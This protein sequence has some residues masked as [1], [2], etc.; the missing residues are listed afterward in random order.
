MRSLATLQALVRALAGYEERP[1][2]VALQKGD[3]TTWSYVALAD[4]AQGLATGLVE[5]GLQRGSHV[6]LFAPN[7]P[8]W[9]LACLALLAAA[10]VPVPVD[11]QSS[12]ADLRHVL[13]DSDARW[14]FTTTTLARRVEA[15]GG[16]RNFTCV[17]LD[18]DDTDRRGWRRYIAD[19]S[20]D[21][22]SVAPEDPAVL[23]YTSGTTG[24]PKGVPLTHRNL[25]ANLQALLGQGLIRDDDRLLLPLPL[26][27]VYPF[28]VGMLAPLATG[29]PIILPHSLTGSQL[30]RAL[31]E[32]RVTA[33]I[34]VPR[35]YAALLAAIETRVRQRGRIPSALFRGA[36][37]V[38][39]ALRRSLEARLGRWLFAP[40][41]KE[42]GP[43]LRV[44]ASGGAALDPDL[45]WGLEGL[46]W[47][48]ASGYGLTETSPILTFN[49]PGAGRVDTAGKPLPGVE[50]RIA[51]P[52]RNAEH[53][54]VLVKGPN[55]FSGYRHL[56][57]KTAEVFTGDGYFRTGD[58]GYFDDE[59]YLHL[60]GRASSLIVLSGG[61]NVWPEK[62]EEALAQGGHIREAGV[63]EQDGQ[64]VA[65]IVPEARATGAN[66]GQDLDQLM[67]REVEQQAHTLPS[68]H[69]ISDYVT[70][71]DP[72]PRTRLG[73]I[74]RHTLA[75]RYAQAK[76]VG[77]QPVQERGPMPLEQ[78][79]PEDRQLL[80]DPAA[81]QVWDWLVQRFADTRLTPDANLQL[82]LGV[83]S[84]EWL[85]L[86][87]E[88]RERTG[89]D[90]DEEAVGRVETVRD[91]LREAAEAEHATGA[92]HDLRQQLQR[93]EELLE[94]RQ[95][96]SLMAPGPLTRAFGVLLL[97]VDRLLM[98]WAFRLEVR[99]VEHLPSQ[100]PFVL[101]P[102]H[103]SFLDPLAV[104]AAL[105]NQH[106]RHTYWGGWTGI[107]FTNPLM[108]LVS[109]A[110]GV[111]PI[112]PRRGPL[113]SLA[114]GA[115]VLQRGH[116][117][118]WF[119]EGERSRDG[120]LQQ[121]RPGVGL[122]LG[123]QPVPVVPVWIAGAY[124][125]LPRGQWWPRLC[126]IAVTFGDQLA[127]EELERQGEGNQPHE[128]IAA[129]LHDRVATLGKAGATK[130]LHERP[131][132]DRDH[133]DRTGHPPAQAPPA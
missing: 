55:V 3:T 60:V 42:F 79:A 31:H 61:E 94:E 132:Q 27:H 28:T 64:L 39:V 71:P 11:A 65:L 15:V 75:E 82:D 85:N 7:R 47:R 18:A 86:T 128:R 131:E 106:V 83:D 10:A 116:T 58:L 101:T 51:E 40:L 91:L 26:H 22:P 72:L 46:G 112:D 8:E 25:T 62:V 6:V 37:A 4:H 56:P 90:L 16:D 78:M 41:H 53:G 30:L 9:M 74:R 21:L 133:G 118:A 13:G 67:R 57:D 48:V 45:A 50:I 68:H 59:G 89:A 125:A 32:G 129:A 52:E 96:Q 44:V 84:L 69:Q 70:T 105:P 108:R 111:V 36:L 54:E 5:A 102:N 109:R 17:L 33:I 43:R 73:K 88:I 110:T 19:W 12:D 66:N 87:L 114:F 2:V 115:A 63:L 122:V 81:R 113:S 24:R 20:R 49:P 23:F 92:G 95:R 120:K 117:L 130:N 77:G 97:G 121:F 104:A 107:M 14:I 34:G 99:G 100:G 103:V 126:P 35:F 80:D 76:Q 119:P 29:V 127:P 93:P 38:S 123:A 98:R 1:A 124:E